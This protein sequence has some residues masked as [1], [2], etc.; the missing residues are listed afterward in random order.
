MGHLEV[1]CTPAAGTMWE[2]DHFNFTKAP[3]TLQCWFLLVSTGGQV[4]HV[5]GKCKLFLV[6][7]QT[8]VTEFF[9]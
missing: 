7:L 5:Q 1:P 9:Q 8:Y 4:S 3:L 6:I 2:A